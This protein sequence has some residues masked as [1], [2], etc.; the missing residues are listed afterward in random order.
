VTLNRQVNVAVVYYS[1]TGSVRRLAESL[2][3]GAVK[4]GAEVRLLR[5][6]ETAPPDVVAARQQWQDNLAETEHRPAPTADDLWWADAI[7]IGCPTRFGTLP[8]PIATFLERTGG[9][10]FADELA[11]KCVGG[12]TSASTTHGGHESTLLAISH[13]FHHWGSIIVPAGYSGETLRAAGNPYGVSA[14]ARYGLP[15]PTDEELNTARAYGARLTATT[16]VFLAGREVA[17]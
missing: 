9:L 2:A 1:A 17:P 12:F 15:G 7:A 11:D 4:Q 6:A 8:S 16:S 13:V 5:C 10:W 14:H 3:E